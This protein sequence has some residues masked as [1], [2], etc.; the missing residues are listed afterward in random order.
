MTVHPEL[1]WIWRAW[2]RLTHDR[3]MH[4]AGMGGSYPGRIPWTVIATWCRRHS[5]SDGE[6]DFMDVCFTAMDGVF[7][8]WSAEQRKAAAK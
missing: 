4:S 6:R 2:M 8:E 7:L 5:Y 1:A 3:P